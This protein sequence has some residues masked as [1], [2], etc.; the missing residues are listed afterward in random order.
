[1]N[2]SNMW[3]ETDEEILQQIP[4]KL[5]KWYDQNAR[6]LPW[7][8]NPQPYRVWVS[9]IMLQQTRVEAVKPYFERFLKALPTV[10]DLAQAPEEQLLKLWE[11]LGYYNRV[12]NLQRGARAVMAEHGGVIPA[13]FEAL[14][15]LPGIGDYTAGAIGS[16]AFQIPVPA[17]DGNVL[18]VIARLLEDNSDISDQSVKKRV[19]D[20]LRPVMP[21]DRPGDFNQA[22]MELGATVC[23]PNGA[24]KCSNCPWQEFCLVGLHGTWQQY[25]QKAAKKARTIEDK[26]ILVIRTSRQVVLRKRPKRGLLAGLYEFPAMDKKASLEEV[27]EW[28]KKQGVEAVRIEKLPESKH[29]FTHKEWHMTGYQV[30]VDELEPMGQDESLL[31]VETQEIERNYPIPSAFA[32]YSAYLKIQ[33]GIQKMKGTTL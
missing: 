13:S 28:L 19:E 17:V 30:L 16:I 15:K 8:E 18:R 12:R 5:L 3:K 29:I 2:E 9:E 31:F 25:P 14:K 32:A 26:T 4:E 6:I 23:L 22:L 24:P 11:G 27:R 1:M 20:D 33:T 21:K 7:R 10:E